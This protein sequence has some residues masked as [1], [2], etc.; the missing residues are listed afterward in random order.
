MINKGQTNA[1]K[2]QSISTLINS[3]MFQRFKAPSSG[4]QC[5]SAELLLI[6]LKAEQDEGCIM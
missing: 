1:S 2:Y 3:Y 5:E 4:S 6:V